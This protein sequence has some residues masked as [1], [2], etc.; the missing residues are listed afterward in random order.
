NRPSHAV[1]DN[2][3]T[4]AH[5]RLAI[6]KQT[7]QYSIFKRGV[8]SHAEA[9][10]KIGLCGAVVTRGMVRGASQVIGEQR[11][12]RVAGNSRRAVLDPGGEEL[13]QADV[14][15][16]FETIHFKGHTVIGPA[17]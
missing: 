12:G 1:V 14:G 6:S 9:W 5:G 13:V 7:A 2:R 11:S 17:K 16:G 4:G 15:N 3:A 8:P 10:P